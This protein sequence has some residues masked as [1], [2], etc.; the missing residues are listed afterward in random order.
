M[1]CRYHGSLNDQNVEPALQCMFVETPDSLRCQTRRGDDPGSLH[2]SD[3]RELPL[4]LRWLGALSGQTKGS[5]AVSGGIH[6]GR[7]AIKAVMAG[8]HGVQVVSALL[9]HG[10]EHLKAMRKQ[11]EDWM[12]EFEWESLSPMRGNMSLKRCPDPTAYERANYVQMLQ[13][14][15][16]S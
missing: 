4:R 10:P 7:D 15:R 9:Q 3:A 2:L 16:A 13:S 6:S 5:L 14:F 11:M 12:E 8:A 1:F